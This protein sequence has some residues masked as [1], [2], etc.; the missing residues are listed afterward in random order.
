MPPF[1]NSYTL[2]SVLQHAGTTSEAQATVDKDTEVKL[3]SI[4]D[5]YD[6]HK[7]DVVQKLLDR[8]TQVKPELHKNLKKVQ[9]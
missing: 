6:G 4:T 3:Q 9:S 7:D 2:S 8:V 5:S 1:N